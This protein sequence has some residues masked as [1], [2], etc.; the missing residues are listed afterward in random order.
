MFFTIFII[1]QLSLCDWRLIYS[2][3]Y[4]ES[5]NSAND[6]DFKQN[7]S[8]NQIQGSSIKQCGTNPLEFL[9]LKDD[10]TKLE[11]EF[12]Y[13]HYQ[14]R[15]ITDVIFFRS[16]PGADSEFNIF[17]VDNFGSSQ[18]HQRPYQEN[19]LQTYEKVCSYSCG[20]GGGGGGCSNVD[21][22]RVEIKTIVLTSIVHNTPNFN[23]SYCFMYQDNDMRIGLRNFLI[24]VK[25][26]HFSC[27]SCSES[28]ELNCLTCYQGTPLGGKCLCDEANQYV[29][30]LIGCTQECN[31]D[32]YLADSKQHCQFD[33]RI[34]SEL[35]YFTS[36]S[37]T[38]VNLLPYQPW[39][40]IPDPFYYRNQEMLISCSGIDLIGQFY[41]Y[42]GIQLE[43]GLNKALKFIRIR[44]SFYLNS[45]QTDSQLIITVDSFS[46]ASILKTAT[47]YTYSQSSL[48]YYNS[49]SC[50]GLNYD[51]VRIETVLK[52]NSYNSIIRFQAVTGLQSETWAF[53]NVTIDYGLCQNNCTE[54]ETYSRCLI[55]DSGY[56]LY[57][58]TCVSSCPIHS[59]LLTNG[60]CQDY[61]DLI[62]I[63]I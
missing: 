17:L 14:I 20:G 50:L 38:N 10:K 35:S 23:I 61:E 31:R 32:Y 28:T 19:D 40:F 13:P 7:C 30:L 48:L 29:Q 34:K 52:T 24:Y 25:P 39:T 60:T 55:C 21:D 12:Y 26:C 5:I 46:R 2:N 51:L 22:Q 1:I 59:I 47:N 9:R 15:I 3:Y 56:Q 41:N 33:P 43:L 63:N 54:C 11:K 6:W 36:N 57:R 27:L 4:S 42:E 45:W 37:L 53:R 49:I 44:V 16:L 18:I 62:E 8:I 58:G